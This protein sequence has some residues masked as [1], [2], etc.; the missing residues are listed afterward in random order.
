MTI[1]TE[2]LDE[3][4]RLLER[5]TPGPWE[6]RLY[7]PQDGEDETVV[8]AHGQTLIKRDA[9]LIVEAFN[10]LPALIA[11]YRKGL[12][13]EAALNERDLFINPD[14]L[15]EAADEIDC[16][17]GCNHIWREHDTGA[18][19]CGKADAGEYCPYDLAETLRAVAKVARQSTYPGERS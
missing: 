15:D 8:G 19:G 5:A 7:A 17:A 11:G 16:G 18:A 3:L 1:T 9:K 14:I 10:C 6:L 4:E 2:K 12:D 13:L